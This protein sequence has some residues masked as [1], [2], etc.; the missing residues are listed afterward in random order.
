[1]ASP[2][3][4]SRGEST[5]IKWNSFNATNVTITPD[6]GPVGISGDIAVSP[7]V[8]TTYTIT[9]TNSNGGYGR[10]SAIVYVRGPG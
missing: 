7:F 10:A 8:T 2:D 3:T 1:M 4:I 9:M 5:H 6:I